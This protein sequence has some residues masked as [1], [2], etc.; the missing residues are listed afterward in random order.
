META[1]DVQLQHLPNRTRPPTKTHER[2][3]LA[4][5]GY[6]LRGSGR[7]VY[8]CVKASQTQLLTVACCRLGAVFSP[9]RVEGGLCVSAR[10]LLG[11]RRLLIYA[12][13]AA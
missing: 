2:I 12:G 13:R 4:I 5:R 6:E 7:E 11:G 3:N 10:F 8:R 9:K 1:R